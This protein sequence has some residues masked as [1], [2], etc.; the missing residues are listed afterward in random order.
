MTSKIKKGDDWEFKAP[1]TKNGKPF[2][3]I[4]KE[5]VS[6]DRSPSISNRTE[7]NMIYLIIR[8]FGWVISLFAFLSIGI[9]GVAAEEQ[10]HMKGWGV[11]DDYNRHYDVTKFEKFKARVLRIKVVTPMPGMAP[12]VAMDVQDNGKIIEVQICPTWFARPDEIGIRKGDRVSIRGVRANINNKDVFM[13]S[14]LKKE[15]Y[16]ELKVRFTK[17]GRPFW[18][19]TPE[20]LF[21]ANKKE[22]GKENNR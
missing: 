18:T 3:T 6:K 11:E 1:L 12:G 17:D 8:K 16:F 4:T 10:L 15:D 22:G 20:A 13:A 9:S 5:A 2:R 7:S 19:M 21:E 14:K